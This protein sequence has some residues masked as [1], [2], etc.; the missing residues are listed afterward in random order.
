MK[1]ITLNSTV[2][3]M[4]DALGTPQ[5]ETIAFLAR[6]SDDSAA[7]VIRGPEYENLAA[8]VAGFIS[9]LN[10]ATELSDGKNAGASNCDA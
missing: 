2:Q 4:L 7:V 8:L 1:E 3:D 6:T 5:G 10:A 9:D